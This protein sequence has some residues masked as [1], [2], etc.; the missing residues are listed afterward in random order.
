M[1]LLYFILPVKPYFR[2][3]NLIL[4]LNNPR[5]RSFIN[6]VELLRY[7][8]LI[9]SLDDHYL[10]MHSLQIVYLW[11]SSLS[12]CL[13]RSVK[14]SA[15]S[16]LNISVLWDG[17]LYLVLIWCC[18]DRTNAIRKWHVDKKVVY[19]GVLGSC[20][21]FV[22]HPFTHSSLGYRAMVRLSYSWL[23]IYWL[24]LESGS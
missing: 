6:P 17:Y 5:Q 22:F 18:N 11:T 8:L 4:L 13:S 24:N 14:V 1:H 12:R 15:I 20:Y 7:F 21:L 9:K 10:I 23:L 19:W 16:M 3:L 2:I